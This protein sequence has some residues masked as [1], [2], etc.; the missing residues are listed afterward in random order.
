MP[1]GE[2]LESRLSSVLDVIYL[3]FNEGYAATSGADLLRTDLVHEALR[4]GRVLARL[5]PNQAEVHGL[6]ALMELQASR[7]RARVAPS[8]EPVL[9][10]DQDRSK[11]D[12]LLIS[13]GVQALQTAQRLRSEPGSFSLQAAIAACH[14]QARSSEDTPWVQISGLYV[15]LARITQSPIIELNRALAAGM[16]YGPEVGLA[17]LDR[18]AQEPLLAG[19][20]YLPSA[21]A[22]LLK[23]LGRRE[24]ARTEFER[25]AKLANN[26]RQRQALLREASSC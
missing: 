10:F 8:G 17:L 22:D 1:R 6:V 4:L 13:R 26:E 23:K 16:A 25:A 20:L 2:D 14:A 21:R 5:A 7:S 18:V 3:I 19:Y 11:W 15:A 9:L 24:E 12:Q